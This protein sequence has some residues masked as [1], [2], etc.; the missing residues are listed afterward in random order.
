ME[1]IATIKTCYS[2]P[3]IPKENRISHA[4]DFAGNNVPLDWNYI[5]TIRN[6]RHGDGNITI[7]YPT[8]DDSEKS[9]LRSTSPAE[10]R[11]TRGN[12]ASSLPQSPSALFEPFPDVDI[13]GGRY[14]QPFRISLSA[15]A[16]LESEVCAYCRQTIIR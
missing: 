3:A 2:L 7:E 13:S 15:P 16:R 9:G 10:P 14:I 11:E 6:T 12:V 8:P 5:T 4:I 1:N